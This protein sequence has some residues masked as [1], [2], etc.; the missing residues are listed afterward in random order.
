M[1]IRDYYNLLKIFIKKMEILFWMM[2]RN[3][4]IVMIVMIVMIA[5]MGK[6]ILMK[7]N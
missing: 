7:I 2:I 4:M 5:M 1:D 6:K 3:A